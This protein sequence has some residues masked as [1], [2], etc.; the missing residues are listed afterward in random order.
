[1]LHKAKDK[2]S[3]WKQT[4]LFELNSSGQFLFYPD[5]QCKDSFFN[6]PWSGTTP[7]ACIM[8]HNSV[9]CG[10]LF[11]IKSEDM[12]NTPYHLA[13][14]MEPIVYLSAI[15]LLLKDDKPIP[16]KPPHTF[17][18]YEMPTKNKPWSVSGRFE[19]NDLT[20]VIFYPHP[21]F[22]DGLDLYNFAFWT[23]KTENHVFYDAP[24]FVSK[25]LLSFLKLDPI[26]GL[27]PNAYQLIAIYNHE[28]TINSVSM[29]TKE[30]LDYFKKILQY[31]LEK[32]APH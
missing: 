4:G 17:P 9:R 27:G 2:Q 8:A 18:N 16:W 3:M 24:P 7:E 22:A 15:D 25:G 29:T 14:I 5:P 20:Q 30:A 12:E 6:I 23:S 19:M 10:I 32:Q 26:H 31:P 13:G 11:F 21:E 1:M 28:I